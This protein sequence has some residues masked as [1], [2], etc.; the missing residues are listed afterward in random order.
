MRV[1][2][3]KELLVEG[4]HAM[5]QVSSCLI[6]S[7]LVDPENLV[8]KEEFPE[9]VQR[10]LPVAVRQLIHQPCGQ[11]R[12]IIPTRLQRRQSALQVLHLQA[13]LACWEE[14]CLHQAARACMK[15][16]SV[17]SRLIL[18]VDSDAEAL[19]GPAWWLG[20]SLLAPGRPCSHAQCASVRKLVIMTCRNIYIEEIGSM[21]SLN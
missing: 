8:V 7:E 10:G 15:R 5:T 11:A 9:E 12:R 4:M 18:T 3:P 17:L 1:I 19:A 21:L 14:A 2:P 16:A 6:L 13:P 20:R